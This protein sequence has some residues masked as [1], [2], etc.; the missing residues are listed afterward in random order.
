[1]EITLHKTGKKKPAKV[2]VSDVVFGAK[3]NESLIQQVLTAF[4]A[5]S[6]RGTKAQ[7]SR[8]EVR[9]G[10]RKPFRQKGLGRARAGTIRSPIWRGGGATFA[11]LVVL[12]AMGMPVTLVALLIS[13]EPLIDMA[14]TALNVNGSMTAGVL[15]GRWFKGLQD[16]ASDTG[17]GGDPEPAATD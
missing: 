16:E 11:A 17:P 9:G 5:G 3:Y 2:K 12:P 15:T 1:M 8:S 7:K 14:R 13:I 4:M 10:G 6:R